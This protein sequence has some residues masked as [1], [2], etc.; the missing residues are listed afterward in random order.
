MRIGFIVLARHD[1]SRLPGKHLRM[2]AGRRALEHLISGIRS[3]AVPGFEPPVIILATTERPVDDPLV[4]FAEEHGLMVYRG[5]L[6][7]VAGRFLEA[8]RRARLDWAFRVNGDNVLTL[9]HVM[10]KMA[11]RALHGDA[12]LISNVPGRT[13]AKGLSCELVRCEVLAAH[14]AHFSD[15]HR[16]HVTQWFYQ[17]PNAVRIETITNEECPALGHVS[18]ALDTAA[19]ARVIEFV[20]RHT[21]QLPSEARPRAI[22]ALLAR[23]QP[24]QPW[25]GGHG[26]LLIAEIGGNHEGDFGRAMALLDLALASRPDFVKF[27]IYT[28]A[29]LV[30]RVASPDRYQHFGRFTLSQDQHL[31]LAERCQASGVGYMASV[32]DSTAYDWIG[33]YI[34]IHKIGSGDLT[35]PWLLR[36]A[37]V[38]GQPIILSTGLAYEEEVVAALETLRAVNA[39]YGTPESLALLQ[40]TSMYPIPADAA[41]LGV[42]ASLR[43]VTGLPIGYSDHTEGLTGLQVAAAMGARILEFHFTDARAGKSFRD[44]RVSL[45]PGEVVDLQAWLDSMVA[46]QGGER[47]R[48][49]PI[50]Q[51]TGHTTSF[52]RGV[53][54]R[55]DLPSGHRVH[56]GDLTVLRPNL[57]IDARDADVLVGKSTRAPI[58]AWTPLSW[59]LFEEEQGSSDG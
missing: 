34:E 1:S 55:R 59:E 26:P 54:A 45:E 42:M 57:G 11:A 36:R 12:D 29:S 7:D 3:V 39:R 37:A 31:A 22:A 10:E 13:F 23:Y 48:P 15:E 41:E 27:Q 50:E 24:S 32:W 4:Y 30:S 46:L 28:P 40:C 20:L 8:A 44:H 56:L 38:T 21:A 53:Y 2:L 18:L 9:P 47:K 35:A 52:R 58:R 19:D 49:L 43:A 17:H 51:E 16:E 6:D 25:I 5:A 33:P 14:R